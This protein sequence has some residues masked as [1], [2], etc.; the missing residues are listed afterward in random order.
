[1]E[2]II[3]LPILAKKLSARNKNNCRIA[4]DYGYTLN[5]MGGKDK[6]MT[7]TIFNNKYLDFIFKFLVR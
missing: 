6:R 7:I 1:M 3:L 4:I 2:G 5:V